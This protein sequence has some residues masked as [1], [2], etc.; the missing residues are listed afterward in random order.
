MGEVISSRYIDVDTD[1]NSVKEKQKKEL[2]IGVSNTIA[3]PV[4][5]EKVADSDSP[6]RGCAVNPAMHGSYNWAVTVLHQE[7]NKANT[8]ILCVESLELFL[9]P[10]VE[11]E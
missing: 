1:E 9:P 3:D 5:R 11:I 8:I 2:V 4:W 6:S 7:H 10:P